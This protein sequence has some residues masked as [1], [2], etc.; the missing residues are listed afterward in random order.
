MANSLNKV[1]LIGNLGRDAETRTSQNNFQVTTFSVATSQSKKNPNGEW[2]NETTWHN[3]VA[4]NQNNIVVE[5]LKKGTKVY[6]EGKI[7]MREYEY[8]GQKKKSFEIVADKIINLERSSG[9]GDYEK[10]NTQVDEPNRVPS[11][12]DS[13]KNGNEADLPF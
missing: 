11:S 4:F 3:I 10:E 5:F 13:T 12:L 1:M 9:T 2:T 6:V 8:E 7:S